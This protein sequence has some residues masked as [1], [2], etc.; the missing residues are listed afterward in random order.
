MS[1]NKEQVAYVLQQGAIGPLC[2]ALSIDDPQVLAVVMDA[3]SNILKLAACSHDDLVSV[4]SQIEECGGLDKIEDLQ[5]HRNE[6]IYKLAFDLID[7]Y[8]TEDVE[9]LPENMADGEYTFG[10]NAAADHQQTKFEF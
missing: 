8:F 7:K 1:G 2:Q 5:N 10:A 3:L 6:E 4:T 9:E